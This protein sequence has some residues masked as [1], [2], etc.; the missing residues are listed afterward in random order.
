MA[1]SQSVMGARF[2]RRDFLKYGSALG[3][4]G[5]LGIPLASA[6]PLSFRFA[7][8]AI[9][10]ETTARIAL[11]ASHRRSPPASHVYPPAAQP[12][13]NPASGFVQSEFRSLDV[14]P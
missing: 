4:W 6:A 1:V 12:V 5:L 11:F 8:S 14:V 10:W 13:A 3:A 2:A 7:C 9:S